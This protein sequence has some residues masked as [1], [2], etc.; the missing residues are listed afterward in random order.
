M[1]RSLCA[2]CLAILLGWSAGVHAGEA[3]AAEPAK[4]ALASPATENTVNAPSAEQKHLASRINALQVPFIVNDEAGSAGRVK[5]FA[6]TLAGSVL[7][8]DQ[9]IT[10]QLKRG[11]KPNPSTVAIKESWIKP[12]NSLATGVK[13]S[14]AKFSFFKGA[15]QK[16]W[17]RNVAAF[18]EVGFGQVYEGVFVTLKAYNNN[19]EKIFS[20]AS[21]AD[22]RRI[23]IRVDGV[24]DL[25]I[26][27]GE[28]EMRRSDSILKMTAPVAYQEL[29]GERK[30]VKAA[31]TRL[32][33]NSYGFKVEGYDRSRPL[34][35]DPL[36]ASTFVGDVGSDFGYAIA[37][38]DTSIY[39]TGWTNSTYFPTTDAAFATIHSGG[40]DVFVSKFQADLMDE[41]DEVDGSRSTKVLE[42]STFIGGSSDDY[43]TAIAVVDGN[44]TVA[45]STKSS[46]FPIP[47]P[48]E[49]PSTVFDIRFNGS[50]DAFICRLSTDLTELKAATF[51]GGTGIEQVY[52]LKPAT[53][54]YTDPD[55]SPLNLLYVAGTTQSKD[56]PVLGD[57]AYQVYYGGSTDIFVSAFD[58]GLRLY[59]ST[60]L[61]GA[62]ADIP[63]AL[64][65]MANKVYLAGSTTSLNFPTTPGSYRRTLVG[66]KPDAFV[67]R[68]SFTLGLLEGSTLLGGTT[69]DAAYALVLDGTEAGV[70]NVYVA[71]FTNSINFPVYTRYLKGKKINGKEDA[72][73]AKLTPTLTGKCNQSSQYLATFLG[74]SA[75]DYAVQMAFDAAKDLVLTGTT[76]SAN[77]LVPPTDTSISPKYMGGV[78]GFVIVVGPDLGSDVDNLATWIRYSTYIGGTSDDR[79][80]GMLVNTNGIYLVGTTK[81]SNYPA[82]PSAGAE[83][84]VT[85]Q[86]TIGGKEDAFISNL[87]WPLP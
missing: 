32:S 31:Y 27:R 78:D 21:G 83:G 76:N 54:T 81:S 86:T 10:Y 39:I 42:A 59:H 69:D 12:K 38:D 16:N 15:D 46:D 14:Q 87:L 41:P 84:D 23:A 19:V 34:I 68:L 17:K 85:Y 70:S 44:V 66:S 62:G 25:S 40:Y 29:N 1:L 20:V 11:S 8:S 9:G 2:V 74:G 61:G 48:A 53:I 80:T 43:G 30:F 22:P 63:Y 73:V 28:L 77:F 79:P 67:A 60:L 37:S 56:F 4:E 3:P 49:G 72:F 55:L 65:V 57:S 51:L 24:S 13:A 45:G 82:F 52:A 7:V 18:D 36:L 71:G 47:I 5:Y 26:N 58:T 75:S 50:Q 35:I 6:K 33:K 64:E